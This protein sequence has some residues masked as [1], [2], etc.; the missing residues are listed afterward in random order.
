MPGLACVASPLS[1]VITELTCASSNTVMLMMSASATSETLAAAVAPPS[2]NG[3]MASTRTSKT[4][5]PPGQS[6]RRLAIGAP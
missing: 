3:A 2:T 1:A 6:S 4:V 5:S